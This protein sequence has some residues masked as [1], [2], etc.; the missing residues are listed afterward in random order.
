MR[1]SE[2][3]RRPVSAVVMLG[4]AS[5]RRVRV[6]CCGGDFGFGKVSSA[7]VDAAAVFCCLESF[8]RRARSALVLCDDFGFGKLLT[9]RSASGL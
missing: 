5:C 6:R 9:A 1:F 7:R 4:L 2:S 3:F 8:W